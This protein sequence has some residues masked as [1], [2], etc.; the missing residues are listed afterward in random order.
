MCTT[1]VGDRGLQAPA[2]SDERGS[3]PL[4]DKTRQAEFLPARTPS[5]SR[6][7][8]SQLLLAAEYAW[9]VLPQEA[10]EVDPGLRDYLQVV[11]RRKVL[12]ALSA[13]IVLGLSLTVSVTQSPRYAA[14]AKLLIRP[15]SA[16]TVF[17][18]SAA[19]SN[20]NSE[21]AVE[22]EIEVIKS[23]PVRALVRE[24]IGSA[25]SVEV[26][27]VGNTDV[28]TIRAKSTDPGRAPVVANA[29]AD[30]YIDFRLK[31]AVDEFSSASNEIRNR[32]TDLNRQ[33]DNLGS[34]LAGAP[35]CVSQQATPDACT[36]RANVEQTTTSRR[37]TL[38]A[39]ISTFQQRLDQLQVDS[40]LTRTGVVLITPASR[41]TEPFAPK[42]VRN[43]ILGGVLG[44]FVGFGLAL[45]REHLD[46]SIKG[47]EDFERAVPGT[48]VLGLIPIVPDWKARE[49]GRVVS[50]TEPN[51]TAAEAYRILRTSIQF[52]GLD[53]AVRII[54]VTSPNA[55]EGKTTTLSNLAVAFAASGLRTVVVDCDLRRP[56][57]HAFFDV[58]NTTG[59]TSVL[60]GEVGLTKA[61]QPVPGQERLLVLASGPL[62]PNPSELLSSRRAAELFQTL[63]S[64]ADV[65]LVDS[66]PCL[67]VT[68]ALVLSQRVDSTIL[69]TTAG[70][71]T[72]KA[73]ARAAEMLLQVKAPLAGAVLNGVTA[74]SGYGRYAYGYYAAEPLPGQAHRNGNGKVEVKG[75][76]G[77]RRAK[78]T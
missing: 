21:R 54:Q 55:S 69:V 66:P 29:Y 26:G 18:G 4:A 57:L 23:D 24:K 67:P 74:E 11:R 77:R 62:P 70:T 37:A 17:S 10:A 41:P 47:K 52:M 75:R 48:A 38:L 72:Q 50:I 63:S 30:A 36:Q 33:L 53:R 42:P 60:L 6:S 45:L 8:R 1:F 15:R 22:T 16:G 25:P 49:E 58:A 28:V 68:D 12:I 27:P 3:L 34:Q 31:Q 7:L 61:L 59:F 64:Q 51:S 32:I 19:Q 44:L 9:E 76:R 5:G 40:E 78:R 35:T 73:A 2:L 65:V 71:T 20:V 43:A 56:R 39:Q 14:G 13:L 46:D